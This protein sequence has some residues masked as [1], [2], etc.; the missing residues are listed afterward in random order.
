MIRVLLAD[1]HQIMREGLVLALSNYPDITIIGEAQDGK[2]ALAQVEAA[3]GR[4][5]RA[6]ALEQDAVARIPLPQF[7][8]QLGDLYRVTGRP[9]LARRQDA[10]I[11]AIKS[12]LRGPD[13]GSVVS[14]A[15]KIE[16]GGLVFDARQRSVK[17][18]DS[19]VSLTKREWQLL[20]FFLANPNQLFA[21]ED[22]AIPAWGPDASIEQFRTYVTRLRHKL[23]PFNGACELINEKGKGYR[24][25]L[26]QPKAL[27]P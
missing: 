5:A 18:A 24:L 27:A 4:Y 21:A 6:I 2:D 13:V 19:A 23:G 10:L 1:D 3:R 15:T 26:H 22:V 20:A 25:A 9:A 17:N 11:G 14:I 7:V 16:L 12:E 8:A